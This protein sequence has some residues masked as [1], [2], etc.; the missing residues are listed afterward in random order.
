MRCD[1]W[2][3][4]LAAG[5]GGAAD[6]R[7]KGSSDPPVGSGSELRGHP[8]EVQCQGE[9]CWPVGSLGWEFSCS[10]WPCGFSSGYPALSYITYT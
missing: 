6:R 3:V 1:T 5:G 7:W 8:E 10:S 2:L 9:S 4:V